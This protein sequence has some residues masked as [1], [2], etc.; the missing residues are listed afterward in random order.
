M[1]FWI[2]AVS[3]GLALCVAVVIAVGYQLPVKHNVVRELRVAAPPS[4]VWRRISDFSAG[5]SW[6]RDLS[7][8]EPVL[9]NGETLWREV[10]GQHQAI[11]YRT[12]ESI[13]QQRLVREI[14]DAGLPFGGR[15]T[16]ELSRD[17]GDGT[18]VRLTEDGEV[19]NPVFRFVSRFVLG[20]TATMDKY[21]A[22]LASVDVVVD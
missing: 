11:T 22:A 17:D 2:A 18:V 15:W 8:V 10:D 19:Y 3:G 14:A 13:A 21:L 12:V 7:S 9:Q 16:F 6:R 4:E 20:H 1:Y 5:P